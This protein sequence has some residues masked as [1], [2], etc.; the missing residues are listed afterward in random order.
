M[1]LLVG[2]SG[3]QYRD[4]RG[5]LYPAE[6]PQRL[7]LECYAAGF[8]TVE[9]N[10]VF[11]RLPST[12]TFASWRDR[13]PPGFC[14]AVKASRFLTHI[15]R[16]REPE[17]PVARLLA[18][19]SGLSEKL[20][21]V[22]LQLPP[23]LRADPAL[24]D[25]CLRCFPTDTRVTVEPRH[26]SWWNAEVR[27]VLAEC[28]AALCWADADSRPVTPLWRTTDWGYLRLHSGRATPPPRYG[29]TALTSWARRLA[30]T[31]SDREDVFVY[32]NNDPGGAAVH[33]AV[34]FAHAAKATVTR[35]P[36]LA[37][38]ASAAAGFSRPGYS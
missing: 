36:D 3:W 15:K 23:T 4:W 22:L 25:T 33:D 27:A 1:P 11:Y 8:A 16:L 18:H 13:T 30:D 5:V 10:S 35:T 14:F 34:A 28:G 12:E 17:E 7:W 31:W 2:T 24:L 9:S 38:P 37:Q 29:R 20:G 19:A 6:L 26:E 32:F 21:P